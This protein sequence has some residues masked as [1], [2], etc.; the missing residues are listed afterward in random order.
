MKAAS[1]FSLNESYCFWSSAI[2]VLILFQSCSIL[3]KSGEYG[4]RGSSEQPTFSRIALSRGSR[5]KA[6]LSRITT[7]PGRSSLIS[8]CSNQASMMALSHIPSKVSGERISPYTTP[9][10]SRYD[11]CDGL[12]ARHNSEFLCD[13]NHKRSSRYWSS[14]Q[15]HPT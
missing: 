9:L 12:I 4:G 6:A 8:C 14:P 2:L 1:T 13:S 11:W 10:P 3:L 15:H 5:W 7:C